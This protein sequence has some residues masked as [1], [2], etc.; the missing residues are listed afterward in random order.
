MSRLFEPTDLKQLKLQNRVVMAPMTRARSS[1]P[2]I[3][4]IQ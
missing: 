4:P 2:G 3:F 1:Q